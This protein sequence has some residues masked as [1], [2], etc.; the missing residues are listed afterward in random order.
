MVGTEEGGPTMTSLS[1][2]VPVV[3]SFSCSYNNSTLP[4]SAD[5][6]TVTCS[7][8]TVEVFDGYFRE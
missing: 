8:R 4:F 1:S 2:A 7:S 3:L 5:C 6:L